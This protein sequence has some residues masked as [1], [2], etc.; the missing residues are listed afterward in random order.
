MT[1]IPRIRHHLR[2]LIDITSRGVKE[3]IVLH[4]NPI[5]GA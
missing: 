3:E 1:R 2:G 5:F 4:V